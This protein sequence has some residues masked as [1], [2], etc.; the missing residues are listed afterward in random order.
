M[1]PK[2]LKSKLKMPLEKQLKQLIKLKKLPLK[3]KLL[4]KRLPLKKLQ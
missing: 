4:F 3:P 1:K 2:Q